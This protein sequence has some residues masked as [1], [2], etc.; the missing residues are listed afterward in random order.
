M[1][2]RDATGQPH[3]GRSAPSARSVEWW[4]SMPRAGSTL[5]SKDEHIRLIRIIRAGG[6]ECP[7]GGSNS[8][9][10]EN[11]SFLVR[12]KPVRIRNDVRPSQANCLSCDLK[13][14]DHKSPILD[15]HRPAFY[16]AEKGR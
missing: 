16:Q 7:A 14:V 1:L 10:G 6:H 2:Y 9:Q 3:P 15:C 5:A 4:A 11:Q 8:T 13:T 12:G